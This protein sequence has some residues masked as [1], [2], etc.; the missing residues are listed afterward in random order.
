MEPLFDVY[1]AGEIV[2]DT[3]RD[4]VITGLATLFKIDTAAAS[5]LINGD[6]HRIKRDCDKATALRYRDAMARVGAKVLIERQG[7]K[8]EPSMSPDQ[9]VGTFGSHRPDSE[10]ASQSPVFGSMDQRP[11][12]A[13]TFQATDLV[14]GRNQAK[15]ESY[16]VGDAPIEFHASS[17][18]QSE[19]V[20]AQAV[21]GELD[22]APLGSP[23]SPE[24]APTPTKPVVVPAYDLAA[25]GAP[26]P[27]LPTDKKPLNPNTDHLSLAPMSTTKATQIKDKAHS[28]IPDPYTGDDY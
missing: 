11:Q 5:K 22:I 27:N 28:P 12:K 8:S 9:A 1:F 18:K 20:V 17:P 24:T 21:T 16:R 6:R 7:N 19:P 23:L 4:S 14:R 15:F 3:A 25:A 13:P 2:G 10:Q 26:I